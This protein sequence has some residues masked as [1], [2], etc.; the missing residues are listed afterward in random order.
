MPPQGYGWWYA[1]GI[2]D[3]GAYGF[4]IIALIGSV[5][6]PYYAW[7]GRHNPH[8]YC[9]L[10]VGI[11]GRGKKRW[12]MTERRNDVVHQAM[13]T[14]AIGPSSLKW[15]GNALTIHI[16]E[17]AVPLPRKVRGTLRVI[18][19]GLNTQTFALD[20]AGRHQWCPIAP[21]ARVEADLSAPNLQFSGHGYIDSNWGTEPLEAGFTHW[22]WSRASL[23]E[24]AGLLYDAFQ[25]DGTN[26]Q[27]ALHFQKDGS[28]KNIP[29]PPRQRL[30]NCPIWRM[31]RTTLAQASIAPKIKAT[32]EDTPFYSRSWMETEFLDE[33][34]LAVHES[35]DLNKFAN[36]IIR[37]ML[38]FRMPRR[39]F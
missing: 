5:F 6:S 31:P 15:D 29:P 33:P 26:R 18:P 20:D 36:P 21:S 24:G 4:S 30:K 39:T 1:D 7:S 35:L 8:D 14:I 19:T 37:T 27:L 12:T 2:S 32:Q 17:W 28:F 10:N 25:R 23:N 22:D 34:T 38:P 16:D 9:A 3:D 11:Y 13:N